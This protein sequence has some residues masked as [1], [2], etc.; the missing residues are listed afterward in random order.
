VIGGLFGR[1]GETPASVEAHGGSVAAGGDIRDNQISIGLDEEGVRRVLEEVLARSQAGAQVIAE[2]INPDVVIGIAAQLAPDVSDRDQAIVALDRAAAELLQLR[3]DRAAGTN[4]G[5]LVD[6]AVRR[7]GERIEAND[8]PGAQREGARAFEQWQRHAADA[9]R[10]ETERREHE[11]AAGAKLA[12]ENERAAFLAGDARGVA[13]WIE[14]RLAVEAEAERAPFALL[15][16]AFDEWRDRG[17]NHGLNLDLA[18]AVEL[19]RVAGERQGLSPDEHGYWLASLGN[20]LTMLGEREARTARLEQAVAAYRQALHGRTRERVPLAWAATQN[21]LGIAL[22]RLGQR[23]VGTAQLEQA[24]HAYQQALLEWTRERVPLDWAGTQN[25]LGTALR[26]LGERDAGTARLEQAV[27]ACCQ[28]LLEWNRERVPLEWATTQNSLGN[29]LLVLG[30]R[31]AGTARLEQAVHAFEQALL[32][33]TP[34]RVPL[35]RAGTTLNLCLAQALIA[36]RTRDP[37]A[38]AGLHARAAEARRFVAEVCHAPLANWG[39][40]VLAEIARIT[41][42]LAAPPPTHTPG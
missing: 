42:A 28:A 1:G 22:M 39:D 29:A 8:V 9:R 21:N 23:Q 17:R 14:R 26:M 38:L 6:E 19:A 10:R 33:W 15:G 25:N 13:A 4:L 31:E 7:I 24:V 11:R 16:A 36:E 2:G 34:E 41:A 18:V 40:Y 32:E 20:V 12:Q 3:Q 5:E 30:E 35:D 27:T 37:A